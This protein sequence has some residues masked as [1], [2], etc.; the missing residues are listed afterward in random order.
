MLREQVSKKTELGLEA[1]Q[2][3]DKGGFVTRSGTD[4]GLHMS[5]LVSDEIVVGMIKDQLENNAACARGLVKFE[6]LTEQ[7]Q[8]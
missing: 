6:C 8:C 5:S 2:I 7:E 4:I 1:K 3:M